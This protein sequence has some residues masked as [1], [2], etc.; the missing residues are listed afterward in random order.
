MRLFRG[1]GKDSHPA[2]TILR[3]VSLVTEMLHVARLF[4]IQRRQLFH[5]R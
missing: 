4:I 5:R 3:I 1:L 2:A